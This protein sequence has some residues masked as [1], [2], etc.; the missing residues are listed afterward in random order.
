MSHPD[1][2]MTYIDP[3]VQGSLVKRLLLHWVGFFVV[4][5]LIAFSLQVLANPFRSFEGHLEQVWWTHGPFLLVMFFLL[6]VFVL[7]TVRLSNRFA[8]P[9]Y[10]LR[11]TLRSIAQGDPIRPLKFRDSDYWQGLAEDFNQ[12]VARLTHS[13]AATEEIDEQAVVGSSSRL[14]K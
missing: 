1:R 8:G 13:D 3:Q 10:R 9:I 12:M 11:Q 14:E 2:K 6:P 7:D 4:A 5:S